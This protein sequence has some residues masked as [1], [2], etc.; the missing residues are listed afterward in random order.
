MPQSTQ[1][2]I[3]LLNNHPYHQGYIKELR[4]RTGLEFHQVET[5]DDAKK[6]ISSGDYQGLLALSLNIAWRVSD[7]QDYKFGIEAVRAAKEKGL[8]TLVLADSQDGELINDLLALNPDS[9]YLVV[10]KP[11]PIESCVAFAK[12]VFR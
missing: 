10:T 5:R 11:C 8:P 3:I 9:K 1:K 12:Y 4:A 6:M 2:K 7:D